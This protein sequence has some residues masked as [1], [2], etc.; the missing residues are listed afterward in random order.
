A[1][2][3]PESGAGEDAAARQA[4]RQLIELVT[5]PYQERAEDILAQVVLTSSCFGLLPQWLVEA[6]ASQQNVAAVDRLAGILRQSPCTLLN[7]HMFPLVVDVFDELSVAGMDQ[8]AGQLASHVVGAVRST[9]KRERMKAVERLSFLLERSLEQASA[10]VRII[11]DALLESGTHETSDEV[12]KLLL[13]HLSK[14][15]QRHHNQGNHT[16]ALEHLEWIASLEESRRLALGEEGASIARQTREELAS[17]AFAQALPEA[18]VL[19]GE[20]GAAAARMMQLLG[21]TAWNAAVARI[22]AEPDAGKA[23]LLA[24]RLREIGPEAMQLFFIELGREEDGAT[25]MRLLALAP[26]LQDDTGL[27]AQLPALLRHAD[28]QVRE[29][30]LQVVMARD[31]VEAVDVLQGA[32]EL[33]ADPAWRK[34]WA[35]AL[36]RLREP[37]G[38]TYLM[39]LLHKAASSAAPN[40]AL[41]TVVFEVLSAAGN[42]GVIE[43]A[44][45]LLK[46]HGHT[47]VLRGEAGAAPKALLLAAVKALAPFYK[48]L[49]AAE[50]L[51][52][53]HKDRDPDV[54]RLAL[55]CLRGIVAAQQQQAETAPAREP[56][57]A[58]TVKP[59]EGAPAPPAA[60]RTRRGFEALEGGAQLDA[61]FRPGAEV[62]GGA[63][64]APEAAPAP[65]A[66][67]APEA[68]P[69]RP[70]AAAA[71]PGPG[72]VALEGPAVEGL[73]P[74][75]E[76]LLGDFG[77]VT[78]LHMVA[79]KDGMLWVE[80]PGGEGRVYVKA[81]KVVSAH[82]A[83]GSGL[84]ALAALD[85]TRNARF[86]YYAKLAAPRAEIDVDIEHLP[87]A[88][89]G[90][91][92]DRDEN[93]RA[94]HAT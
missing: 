51:E 8:E 87:E 38:E 68:Q 31:G 92:A 2:H 17:S 77:L 35:Q 60:R 80:G 13:E 48:D 18:L 59:A 24:A 34:T 89:R 47:I 16:R 65:V 74:L 88:L 44:V 71:E 85:V 67:A 55:V 33:E 57:A 40:E 90:Y 69:E 29:A 1:K 49:I 4:L 43:P 25:A 86:A 66:D 46:P 5:R 70:A 61:L 20:Q 32:L 54:A 53:L 15:C 9:T 72:A 78:T 11:E 62:G 73:K 41:V 30:A 21:P 6:H 42:R 84:A 83:G 23:Q 52:R 63:R 27:W 58:A 76:G 7:E 64:P 14:R 94:G 39:D 50:T 81:R 93:L 37:A 79:G 19:E 26:I 91:R 12:L 36:A 22:R 56:G 45:A 28:R 82:Y 75:L 10:P 3:L